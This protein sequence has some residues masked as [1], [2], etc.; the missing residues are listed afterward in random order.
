MIINQDTGLYGLVGYPIG[1]SLSPAVHNAAFNA[2]GINA[3]YV[4]FETRD[5][6]GSLRGMKALGIKGMSVT[7]PHKSAVIPLLDEADE[8]VRKIGAVNTIVN[9]KGRLI[10]YNTDAPAALKA[11]EE[12][13]E[14][15]NRTCLIIG[16]GGAARA[17]GFILKKK[18]L[19]LTIANRSVP[20]GEELANFL[21]CPF[22]PLKET[23]GLEADLIVQTTPVGMYPNVDQCIISPD[24]LKEG[25]A[26]MDIVYNPVE[27]R[28]L[29]LAKDRGCLT[30]D[31][32]G[33]FVH[34][35]AEQF[36]LWTG[37]DAPISA[38]TK[39]AREAPRRAR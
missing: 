38:M 7:I 35:A 37:L 11:L 29:T 13:I 18:G 23:E 14:L 31:G 17:V 19:Q 30:I 36:M 4:A 12:K 24:L 21:R 39:A 1:H 2:R 26:V 32:L 3:V 34:Q 20:R 5:I 25:I 16:A 9:D 22:I 28:L 15:A 6:E 33:M 8:L 10:G 27:T